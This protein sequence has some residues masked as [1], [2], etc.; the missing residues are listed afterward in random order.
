MWKGDVP[1]KDKTLLVLPEQGFGD[2]IQFCR[3]VPA[4]ERL[5]ARVTILAP[6]PL[7]ALLSTV[8][9]TAT[10]LEQGAAPLPKCDYACP[11][12]SLPLAFKTTVASIPAGVP[13]LST[14]PD[15]RRFWADRLGPRTR[16]RV[17]LAWTGN[18]LHE[19]DRNRSIPLGSLRPILELPLD[20]HVLQKDLKPDDLAELARAGQSSSP[21]GRH[22]GF[23]GCRRV[24]RRDGPGGF[25]RH[26]C[27]AF[28]R[29]LGEAGLD[30][31][32]VRARLA[33]DAE[34]DR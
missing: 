6:S 12:A 1:I 16:P 15:R 10:V 7:A 22:Q 14:D 18:P 31:A 25:R 29:R 13:Y 8:S 27:G 4:L 17:G 21:P 26:R 5:G 20:F 19:N 34:P 9:P 24:D 11:S 28:G 32:A 30:P 2:S 23:R 3:Y 33:M